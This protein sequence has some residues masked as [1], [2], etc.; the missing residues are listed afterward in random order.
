MK[1]DRLLSIVIMLLNRK[2][3]TAKDLADYFEVSIR[4]IQRDIEA[5]NMAGIPI[6]SYRGQY[7]GYG[8]L[9]NYKIDKNFLSDSEH[10]LL[11]VALEGINRAYEDKNLKNVIEKLTSIKSTNDH[12]KNNIIMDFSPWGFSKGLKEK[13]DEIKKAIE[14]KEIIR[15][16]YI[17]L[18]GQTTQRTVEPYLLALKLN[19]WYLQGY[20]RL[21]QDFRLFKLTRIKNLSSIDETFET[22]ENNFDFSFSFSSTNIVKLKLKFHPKALNRLDDYFEFEKLDFNEDGYIYISIEYPED[23]WVYSM[24]LSFGDWVEV[25][26]P[27]HIRQ[28][29]KNKAK[30][31][32]EKYKTI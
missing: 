7:G 13:I 2:R 5:I 32:L 28:I 30:N 26:E 19:H 4:T 12:I 11:L 20:C 8:L 6:V 31:I 14:Q 25:I 22:R 15:F 18:N 10:K 17:N 9:D 3:I 27:I 23:E 24:I 21:R 1:I 16:T 29:I